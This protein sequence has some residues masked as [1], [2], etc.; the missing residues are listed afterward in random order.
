MS[1]VL[2]QT[3]FRWQKLGSSVK[4][5]ASEKY[6]TEQ[7]WASLLF[8]FLLILIAFGRSMSSQEPENR[9]LCQVYCGPMISLCHIQSPKLPPFNWNV[10]KLKNHSWFVFWG[11]CRFIRNLCQKLKKATL[12]EDHR[13]GKRTC[14]LSLQDYFLSMKLILRPS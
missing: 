9:C 1:T 10:T 3:N 4:Y 14:D 7:V 2:G 13:A 5:D 12:I 11:T 6:L 8:W